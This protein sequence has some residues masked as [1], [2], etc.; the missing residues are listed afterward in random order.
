MSSGLDPEESCIINQI[1]EDAKNTKSRAKDSEPASLVKSTHFQIKTLEI[2][3]SKISKAKYLQP[4]A[5]AIKETLST[6]SPNGTLRT[7]YF[8]TFFS[9]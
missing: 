2:M 8:Q 7:K 5:R 1:P 4:G 6:T 3:A 9:E